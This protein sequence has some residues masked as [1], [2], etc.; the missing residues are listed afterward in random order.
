MSQSSYSPESDLPDLERRLNEIEARLVSGNARL[1]VIEQGVSGWCISE[2]IFHL[3]LANE[4]SL[5]NAAALHSQ[6]GRLIREAVDVQPETETYL[7]QGVIPRGKQAPRFVM[8]PKRIDMDILLELVQGNRR[9]INELEPYGADLY[10]AP[11]A[12]PHQLVGDMNAVQWVRFA[13]VHTDHHWAII[14]EIAARTS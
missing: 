9:M 3:A 2:H 14:R 7:Q 1:S 5:K 10:R 6:R 4:L 11:H 12:I 8:P 13:R